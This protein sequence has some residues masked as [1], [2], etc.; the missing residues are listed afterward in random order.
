MTNVLFLTFFYALLFPAGFFWASGT[1]G[2]R[3][4]VD[5]FCLLRNWAPAPSIGTPIA[6]L[7]RIYF[8][9]A[10]V[11]AYAIMSS[12]NFASFPYD[13]ACK[14]NQTVSQLYIG[15]FTG[16]TADGESVRIAISNGDTVYKYCNQDMLRYNPRPA[17]PAIPT[18]QPKG[19][20]WMEPGQDFAVIFGWTS[21][22]VIAFVGLLYLE[23][24][25]KRIHHFLFG[26]YCREDKPRNLNFSETP[27]IYGY[28]PQVKLE[29]ALYPTLF[30]DISKISHTLIDWEDPAD[31]T[32]NIH[33]AIYDLPGL[34][35]KSDYESIFSIVKEWGPLQ[36]Q[37][38]SLQPT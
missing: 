10:A 31:P 9:P 25:R 33:N 23:A 34:N 22:I 35:K 7:S 28:I 6:D 26:G 32:K 17:F 29:G 12:Y 18:S 19:G 16:T 21:V 4:W 13:N 20:E 27:G 15:N 30:C 24:F 11:V 1:L 36:N 14:L 2:V 8:F 37:V 5:K 38:G 3:Y